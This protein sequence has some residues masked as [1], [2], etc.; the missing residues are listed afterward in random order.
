MRGSSSYLDLFRHILT[1]RKTNHT[2]IRYLCFQ[3]VSL[4]CHERW[5]WVMNIFI[6]IYVSIS[7]GNSIM[8]YLNFTVIYPTKDKRGNVSWQLKH[9]VTQLL[10]DSCFFFFKRGNALSRVPVE[11][12]TIPL[13]LTQEYWHQ[14]ESKQRAIIW[15]AFVFQQQ[16]C[17]HFHV[18][19]P[20]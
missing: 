2:V 1:A 3:S 20:R 6:Y 13:V 12:T 8:S 7:G 17:Q 14:R 19:L 16:H 15:R 18:S 4:M 9:V 5:W 11:S 10:S